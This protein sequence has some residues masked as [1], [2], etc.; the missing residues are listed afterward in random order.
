MLPAICESRNKRRRNSIRDQNRGKNSRKKV[1]K[2]WYR[3]SIS[4][5]ILQLYFISVPIWY[6]RTR[7]KEMREKEMFS[8]KRVLELER[9]RKKNSIYFQNQTWTSINQLSSSSIIPSSR[10]CC[11]RTFFRT[12]FSHPFHSL[13]AD[14]MEWRVLSSALSPPASLNEN[15]WVHS[16]IEFR[17]RKEKF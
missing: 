8:R 15:L 13:F 14:Q 16:F 11:F 10:I 5:F 9:R 4:R 12:F 6:F 17:W 7:Q 2:L 1:L 3:G